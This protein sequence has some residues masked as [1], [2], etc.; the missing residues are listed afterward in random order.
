MQGKFRI[1]FRSGVG[2]HTAITASE[3]SN[4]NSSSVALKLSGE[5]CNRTSVP[6]NRCRRSWTQRAPWIAMALISSRLFPN[7]TRR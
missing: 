4:A 2:C 1:I 6:F 5:Y 7:T 3:I